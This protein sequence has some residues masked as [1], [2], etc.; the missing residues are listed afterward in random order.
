MPLK[1]SFS[2]SKDD[3]RTIVIIRINVVTKSYFRKGNLVGKQKIK[4][5][6]INNKKNEWADHTE[7]NQWPSSGG[8]VSRLR[9]TVV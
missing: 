9:E 6:V 3:G 5:S 1:K 8:H 4:D 2:N 7:E